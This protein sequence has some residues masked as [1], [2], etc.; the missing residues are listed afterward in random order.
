MAEECAEISEQASKIAVRATKCLRFGLDETQAGQLLPNHQRLW[1][2]L[3]DLLAFGE[4][5]LELG[6]IKRDHLDRKKE[7]LEK[8]AEYSRRLGML[9]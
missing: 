9:T 8:F 5:A 4:V 7:K 1:E 2:E 3:A 6:I